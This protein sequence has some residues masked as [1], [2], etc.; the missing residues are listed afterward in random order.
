MTEYAIGDIQGCLQPLQRLLHKVQFSPRNDCLWVVGDLVNRGPDSLEV[1][2]FL[3]QMR[4]SL[5]VVLGNH[6]LH[7]LAIAYGDAAPKP[8][9]TLD[10]V[11]QA[12]DCE[13]LLQWLRGQPLLVDEPGQN[14]L[15][16]HAGLPHI[17]SVEQASAYA[18]EVE[19]AL[20][21][22]DY[23]D[24][25]RQFRGNLPDAWDESLQGMP[26][27]RLIC[28]YL[29]RMRLC[30]ADGRL[31][32][33]SKGPPEEAPAGYRPWYAHR[34]SEPERRILFGHWSALRGHCDAPGVY[35]L[36]RGCVWGGD[37]CMLRLA[38]CRWFCVP[39]LGA[40]D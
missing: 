8:G 24:F 7:L 32:L 2:R 19:A 18:R 5:R 22:E 10:E 39:G 17:W 6:D 4:T 33:R 15:M 35:A 27:L 36:D 12:P 26:R 9:D 14:W 40:G 11:L 28:N 13:Q 21:G 29:L 38:D 23:A 31:A 34:R 37:L 30:D 1:L 25:L 3:Y 16:V 20:R